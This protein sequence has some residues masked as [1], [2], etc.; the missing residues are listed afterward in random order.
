MAFMNE[1]ISE[2][3]R[4][5]YGIDG[6]DEDLKRRAQVR[7]RDW[8]IDHEREI[9]LRV[10]NRGREE[11]RNLSVWH[12]YWH[13]E[14]MT[15]WLELME[16]GGERGGHGWSHYRLDKSRGD[17]VPPHLQGQREEVIADLRAALSARKGGGVY[18][19]RT[20]S[21]TTLVE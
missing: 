1:Y 15:V 20:T 9:Y 12:F 21:T 3:D 13:G 2:D 7:N 6:I 5:K 8:T 19:T 16:A 10:I 17:F 14:L 11:S 4:K 18:S